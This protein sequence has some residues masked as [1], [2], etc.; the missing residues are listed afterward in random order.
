MKYK[1]KD[2]TSGQTDLL[3]GMSHRHLNFGMCEGECVESFLGLVELSS[4]ES[5]LQEQET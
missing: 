3:D 1:D 4:N 2:V 5:L